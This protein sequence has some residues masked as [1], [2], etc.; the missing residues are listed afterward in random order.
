[1]CKGEITLAKRDYY[2][3]LGVS[4][5][6]SK[7]EIKKAYRKL[8]K[9]YHPDIN[10]EEGADAK[11]KEISEAYEVL[12]D[13]NKRAQYDRF[14]HS[15]PQQGFGG[16]Q[17]FGGQD[18]SGFGGFED[19][20]GS[21]FGGGGARRDPNAPRQG[22]DLQYSM[23]L[24]FEEAVF[25][26][27]KDITVRK[28]V[29]CETCH[30]NGA[31]PGTK[32]KTCTYCNGQGH[33]TVEQNTILGRM[34]TQK[35]CP[36]CEG[37]GQVFEEKCSDCHGKGTQ[38]KKVTIKVKVPEGVDNDQQIRLAG[39]GGPG[40]NG[41]PAGDLYVVFRVKPH[42]KFRRDG[43]NIFYDLNL[44][45]PQ[46]ALGDEITVP[47]LTGNVSLTVPAGTQTGK[48]F[49]LREKGVQNVHGYG[50]GDYF[51]TVKVVTPDKMTERQEELLR[52]FAEIGGE[53][54]TEQPSSFKDRAKKFFK[55]E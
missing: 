36:E 41:G 14:G 23:T 42:S 26:T 46:A 4:K 49:R 55:G 12:S 32:K 21:F 22:D 38:N 11:F 24:T 7:D 15:G 2:E 27:E 9:K 31:K 53:T 1:M 10:Q 28:D 45:F 52:E 20:F 6:A 50:K 29:E 54:I 8:S 51:V 16:S 19:I 43:D 35:V 3:V 25:G 5:D 30:G 34:Q 17:G 47:T 18:F 13:E 33:V 40:I 44:S 48:Q 39:K 37:S